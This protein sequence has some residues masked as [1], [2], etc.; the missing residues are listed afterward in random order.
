VHPTLQPS[1]FHIFRILK[2]LRENKLSRTGDLHSL[3]LFSAA[4]DRL[5]IPQRSPET[6]MNALIRLQ[7][8]L[9]IQQLGQ[10]LG[11][12]LPSL[13]QRYLQAPL[14]TLTALSSADRAFL[15]A[16][17]VLSHSVLAS[18]SPSPFSMETFEL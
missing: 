12:Q 17:L 8:Q 16:H 9:L 11:A 6:A 3:Q 15:A 10:F 2:S 4:L 18:Q 5:P 14:P 1:F 13:H 7:F